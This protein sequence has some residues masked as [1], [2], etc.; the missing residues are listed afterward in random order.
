MHF[1]YNVT[2]FSKWVLS[3][4]YDSRGDRPRVITTAFHCN[5][6]SILY[7]F[8]DKA[9][10]WPKIARFFSYPLQSTPPFVGEFP[11]EYCHI[12][13]YGKTITMCL[14][15]LKKFGDIRLAVS[16]EYRGVSLTDWQRRTSCDISSSRGN[17]LNWSIPN[18]ITIT[19]IISALNDDATTRVESGKNWWWAE[20]KKSVAEQF[21]R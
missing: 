14:P 10:Y 15:T 19:P 20:L 7:R 2:R 21:K 11:S 4:S 6:G 18:F 17:Q 16:T 13:C 3:L 12:V 1:D 8:R 9:R 5:Y